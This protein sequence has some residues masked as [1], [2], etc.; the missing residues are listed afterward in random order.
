MKLVV[1]GSITE[2]IIITPN[3]EDQ[4]FVGGV[5][6]YAAS[7]AKALNEVIGI[8]SK[9]GTDFPIKNL[10]LINS[11][12]ADL[13][14]FIITGNSSMKFENKYN[15]KGIRTQRILSVSEKISFC[16][17]PK[18]YY[19]TPCIHLGPVFN[20]I[21][22]ELIT[23]VRETFSFV[24]LDGQGFTR[25]MNKKTKKVILKP[26]LNYQQFLP[27]LDVLK[28]DD[29]E[30]MGITKSTE[31][32]KAIELALATD[33]KILVITRAQNGAIIFENKKRYDIPALPTKVVDA[34][35]AGDTFITTFLIEYMQTKN[36]YHSALLAAA[37]SSFKISTSGPESHYNRMDLYTK[38]RQTI[39]NFE[40]KQ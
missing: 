31:L 13:N 14:G 40:P 28:V 10:R 25:N 7:T 39:P 22:V 24:S 2:D 30:L 1:L 37:A 27:L 8:V 17:I 21:D 33:I 36:A 19:N 9:V 15:K 38:L 20:E 34:T 16:D 12:G 26:W 5:P 4:H 35:G 6:I 18:S 3:K 32:N 11:L 23:K 29:I